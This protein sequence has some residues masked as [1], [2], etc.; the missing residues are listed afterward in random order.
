VLCQNIRSA[1]FSFATKQTCDRQTDGNTNRQTDSKDRVSIAVSRGKNLML[2]MHRWFRK[3]QKKTV[4][5]FFCHKFAKFIPILI[6]F[7]RKMAKRLK[8][9]EVHW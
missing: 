5:K 4:Q 9:Y 8:L 2:Q 1:L 3:K 6:M 7:D